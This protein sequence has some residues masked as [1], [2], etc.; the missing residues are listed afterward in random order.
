MD[1]CAQPPVKASICAEK[2]FN[3]LFSKCQA[4]LSLKPTE[5]FV[6]TIEKIYSAYPVSPF[7]FSRSVSWFY[8][9]FL[10]FIP[11]LIFLDFFLR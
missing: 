4:P 7:Q 5:I 3:Q 11:L 2:A 10:M 8:Q 6:L 9:S 1:F